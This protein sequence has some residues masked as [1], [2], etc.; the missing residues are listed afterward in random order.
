M[1]KLLVVHGI[2]LKKKDVLKILQSLSIYEGKVC[3][4]CDIEISKTMAPLFVVLVPLES[5]R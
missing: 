4:V 1:E 5:P 2:F 3:F